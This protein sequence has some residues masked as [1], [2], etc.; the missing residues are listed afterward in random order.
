[1]GATG[2]ETTNE[3]GSVTGRAQ[4][5]KAVPQGLYSTIQRLSYHSAVLAANVA[6]FVGLVE[7]QGVSNRLPH[8]RHSVNQKLHTS[9]TRR[10]VRLAWP[11]AW[12]P[13]MFC[14][15]LPDG[16]LREL[17]A[18]LAWEV[19]IL[20]QKYKWTKMLPPP[21]RLSEVHKAL[22]HFKCKYCP[23]T[24]PLPLSSQLF[25]SYRW[26]TRASAKSL[27]LRTPSDY[28]TKDAF[29]LPNLHS[30]LSRLSR[31]LHVGHGFFVI[32]RLDADRYTRE[33]NNIVY[34]GVST[35]I[36]SIRGRQYTYTDGQRADAV[37]GHIQDVR[38]GFGMITT[39]TNQGRHAYVHARYYTYAERQVSTFSLSSTLLYV[40]LLAQPWMEKTW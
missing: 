21:E 14:R 33:E 34:T 17:K 29:P 35:H 38:L 23:V 31:K 16:F 32:R 40:L 5:P 1:M 4:H 19:E 8:V 6:D 13:K 37:I 36:G 26:L 28:I 12:P 25:R 7:G 20:A 24:G 22:G 39:T 18:D 11:A 2:G 9:P 30:E 3:N 27:G 10:N 15:A